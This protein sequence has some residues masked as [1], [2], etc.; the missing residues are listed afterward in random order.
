VQ[1][2]MVTGLAEM[3]YCQDGDITGQDK[4]TSTDEE[5]SQDDGCA[6]TLMVLAKT[7]MQQRWR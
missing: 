4:G 3:K 6:E 5:V 7:M 1:A 2:E